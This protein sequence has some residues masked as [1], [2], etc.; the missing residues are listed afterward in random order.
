MTS[1]RRHLIHWEL[2]KQEE[3]I[4]NFTVCNMSTDDLASFSS[5]TFP[6]T[7]M[8]KFM[9]VYVY[10]TS[11]WTR[12]I[13]PLARPVMRCILASI[14]TGRMS[15][16]S[17][18]GTASLLAAPNGSSWTCGCHTEVTNDIMTRLVVTTHHARDTI[19]RLMVVTHRAC[20]YHLSCLTL[21]SP[22]RRHHKNT[23]STSLALC[24]GY[25]CIPI[26]ITGSQ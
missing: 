25:R 24:A 13:P 23:L 7:G 22:W 14:V 19:T 2:E 12:F 17:A 15:S 8:T 4:C 6:G 9:Y 20:R 10:G 1:S 11:I 26:T 16:S 18:V 5:R 3:S 21:V